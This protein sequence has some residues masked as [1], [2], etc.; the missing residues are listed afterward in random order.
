M[1][2]DVGEPVVITALGTVAPWAAALF[3]IPVVGWVLTKFLNWGMNTLIANGVIDIKV[4][5][6][7]FMS[8]EA[9]A[10]WSKQIEILKQVND[11]G[12]VMTPDQWAAYDNALQAVGCNHP[13][14]VGA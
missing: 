13:G 9:K 14:V 6:I 4:G 2:A 10:T 11:A 3:K 1:W 8:N 5:I 12:G 7:A